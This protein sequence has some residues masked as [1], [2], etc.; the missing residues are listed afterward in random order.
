M[1]M[2]D[3]EFE[4]LRKR[5]DPADFGNMFIKASSL[6]IKAQGEAMF[7]RPL[8]KDMI[9]EIKTITFTETQNASGHQKHAEDPW[10][11]GPCVM[12]G[13]LCSKSNSRQIV[14]MGNRIAVIKSKEAREYV[15]RFLRL[16]PKPAVPYEGP[17]VLKANVYYGNMRRDLDVAL[18]CD[19]IQLNGIIKNDRNIWK[20]VAERFID[21]L[22][23]RTSFVLE[24]HH[25]H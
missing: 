4:A 17:V 8:I 20:I 15:E 23:P 13:A 2:T 5:Q 24:A 18:L 3:A 14:R 6:L 7:K 21:K 11:Y 25:G 1:K 9:K 10:S 22:N 12:P 19:C 16:M